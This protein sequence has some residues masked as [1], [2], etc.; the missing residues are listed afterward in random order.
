MLLDLSFYILPTTV[1]C[2]S[3]LSIHSLSLSLWTL[4]FHLWPQSSETHHHAKS[5]GVMSTGL[6]IWKNPNNKLC[7]SM[8]SFP[9][10]GA[11][12]PLTAS[13]SLPLHTA[14]FLELLSGGRYL[15]MVAGC[16]PG[17]P[18][19]LA[20]NLCRGHLCQL[21]KKQDVLRLLAW[22][23]G[24][25]GFLQPWTANLQFCVGTT[26]WFSGLRGH[27]GFLNQALKERW[28]NLA[29]NCGFGLN[30]V[31]LGLVSFYIP[32]CQTKALSVI[33]CWLLLLFLLPGL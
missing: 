4:L 5:L 15:V 28:M 2:S 11:Y 18:C 7:C 6:G 26:F 20:Q 12:V 33:Y 27:V 25:A 14:C 31:C 10:L 19:S 8:S 17:L 13:H 30:S 32:L 9:L 23:H 29:L 1:Y 21:P 24:W 22:L 3:C 16:W